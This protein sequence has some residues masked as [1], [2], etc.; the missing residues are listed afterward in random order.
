MIAITQNKC[1]E[2]N[3]A[4]KKL[5]FLEDEIARIK[6]ETQSE[7]E[8]YEDYIRRYFN[9]NRIKSDEKKHGKA[10]LSNYY[11]SELVEYIMYKLLVTGIN[12]KKI[13]EQKY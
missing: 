5:L 8:K 7:F 4:L 6:K 2:L 13:R 11:H 9:Y 12:C 1:Q 10:D 3:I